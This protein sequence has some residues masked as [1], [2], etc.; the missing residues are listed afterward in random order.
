[1]NTPTLPFT[2]Y[3]DLNCPLCARE[4]RWLSRHANPQDL[5]LV[6]ISASDFDATPTGRSVQELG[7]CLHGQGT[8]GVWLTGIDATLWSWRAA[9]V[10]KWAAPLSWK[11]LRPLFLLAYGLFRHVR[12][13]L[14]WLPHP[15]GSRR[16]RN[17]CAIDKQ[18]T[19]PSACLG[20]E[21]DSTST[22]H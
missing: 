6:D 22:Q 4:V 16:C 17:T 20:G 18:K 13:H 21:D 3:V 5:I 7:D 19:A 10:G 9:G 2:L 8:D 11:P 12:P 1:M 14:S 15:D